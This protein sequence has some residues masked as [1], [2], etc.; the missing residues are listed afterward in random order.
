MHISPGDYTLVCAGMRQYAIQSVY[1]H[2]I[3]EL[4]F[5]ENTAKLWFWYASMHITPGAIALVCAGMRRYAF[6]SVNYHTK[7]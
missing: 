2:T 1:L 3:I 7:I 5:D 4:V 6:Q